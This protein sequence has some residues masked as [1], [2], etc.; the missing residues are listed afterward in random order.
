MPLCGGL[1][2]AWELPRASV[3]HNMVFCCWLPVASGSPDLPTPDPA[4]SLSF[5]DGGLPVV[6]CKLRS[7]RPAA[8]A[9]HGLHYRDFLRQFPNF[10]S[11]T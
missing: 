8:V 7:R 1:S 4:F 11:S 5:T 6:L 10:H 2:A 9:V 3:A